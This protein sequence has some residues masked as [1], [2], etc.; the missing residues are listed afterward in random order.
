MILKGMEGNRICM[1][2]PTSL[3]SDIMSMAVMATPLSVNGE[4]EEREES[5]VCDVIWW[6]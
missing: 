3:S 6:F 5:G 2:A 4:G 1:S